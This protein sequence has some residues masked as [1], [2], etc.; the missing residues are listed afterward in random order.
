MSSPKKETSSSASDSSSSVSSSSSSSP[1]SS[2]SI[3][4]ISEYLKVLNLK[5]KIEPGTEEIGFGK[6]ASLEEV[7]KNWEKSGLTQEQIREGIDCA[8][9]NG[10]YDPKNPPVK[11]PFF[12]FGIGTL[13]NAG[14]AERSDG[15]LN[16]LGQYGKEGNL[17]PVGEFELALHKIDDELLLK[18]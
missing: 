18:K 8:M 2:S 5:N 12:G 16:I 10:G 3:E 1:D 13:L 11:M 17:Q 15:T 4:V 6:F 9:R 7:S 14:E